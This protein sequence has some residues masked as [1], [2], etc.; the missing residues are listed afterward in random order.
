MTF[1]I[2]TNIQQLLCFFFFIPGSHSV[3]NMTTPN[4]NTL[5]TYWVGLDNTISG[6]ELKNCQHPGCYFYASHA[7]ARKT[8]LRILQKEL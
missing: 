2:K 7:V 8:R 4:S 1:V 3:N 6:L 5:V